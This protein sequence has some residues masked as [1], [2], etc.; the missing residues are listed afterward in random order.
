MVTWLVG[1]FFEKTYLRALVQVSALYWLCLMDI[2]PILS[3]SILKKCP[4]TGK[5]KKRK[6]KIMLT[7][8]NVGLPKCEF[9]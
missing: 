7:F 5:E 3:L 4:Q 2:S 6:T 9:L 8:K 1:C